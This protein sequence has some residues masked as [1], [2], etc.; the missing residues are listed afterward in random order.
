MV[1]A[2]MDEAVGV[3]AKLA[4]KLEA[5]EEAVGYE[6]ELEID[7]VITDEETGKEGIKV[8]NHSRKQAY[9]V[10]VEVIATTPTRD[11]VK[12]LVSGDPERMLIGYSRIVGYFS[13]T[14][15]WS[16]SKRRELEDRAKGNYG[17]GKRVLNEDT[18]RAL[19]QW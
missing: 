8:L 10:P 1:I 4:Q 16:I 3:E 7:G 5:L 12:A 13:R 14:S 18:E 11:L 19:K 15:N 9:F 17:T 6:N 2:E